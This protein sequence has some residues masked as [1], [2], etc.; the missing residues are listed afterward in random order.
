MSTACRPGSL[1]VFVLAM[2]IAAGP[3]W[4]CGGGGGTEESEYNPPPYE[5]QGSNWDRYDVIDLES[6][7]ALNPN[8]QAQVDRDGKVHIF[9]YKRGEIYKGNQTRYQI[10]HV[11]W[12]PQTTEIEGEEEIIPVQ[13]PNPGDAQ[14]SG[15]N[16]C[17]VLD[18]A[19]TSNG[20][21]VIAYQGGD[22]PQAEDGTIC[23]MTAQGDLMIN[24][25]SGGLW[26]EY[27]GIMG[28]ASPKNPYFTDGYIGVAASMVIDSQDTIHMCGQHY[29]EFC[30]WTSTNY[31]DLL[32]VRQTLGQL[33]HYSTAMEEHVDDY[34]I[35]RSGGGVQSDM[36]YLCRLAL[37]SQNNPYIFYFGTPVQDGVGEDRRSLR[38]A[39]KSGNQWIPESIEVLDEWDVKWLSGAIDANGTPAVAYFMGDIDQAGD[40]PDH[41][42]YAYRDTA[43]N[44]QIS[45]VDNSAQCGNYCALAFDG[46]NRPAIAYYDIAARSASYRTHKDLKFASFNGSSWQVETVATAGAIGQYNTLWFDDAGTP[47]ICAYEH[48][49]QTIAILRKRPE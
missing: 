44:W 2:L 46:Q 28:D 11:V 36:G 13:S 3:F 16:N 25:F 10:H 26:E 7:A 35:F 17:L 20:S 47:F 15:L 48:N 42:R 19:V 8:V 12:D 24:R 14:D 34:N 30:D 27:L 38:M 4:A 40:Y 43:G 18:A 29:Y 31:P 37:D 41:L 39:V 32:Y 23:N 9:Y 21:P 1:R 6:T 5:Y 45:V 22:V 49:E 33:G